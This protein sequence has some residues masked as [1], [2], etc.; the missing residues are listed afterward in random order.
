MP[1][2]KRKENVGF[3]DLRFGIGTVNYVVT[4]KQAL[5]AKFC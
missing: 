5:S 4:H 2:P 1:D 3:W